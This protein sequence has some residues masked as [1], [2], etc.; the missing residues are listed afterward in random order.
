VGERISSGSTVKGIIRAHFRRKF[1]IFNT[2]ISR[3]SKSRKHANVNYPID[4]YGST[5]YLNNPSVRT[6]R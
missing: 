2:S 5:G 3:E 4:I 1:F 6:G